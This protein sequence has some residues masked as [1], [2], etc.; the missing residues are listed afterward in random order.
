MYASLQDQS[1][2]RY[3]VV[4]KQKCTEWPQSDL[5]LVT[6]ESTCIHWMLTPEAQIS[7]RDAA[8]STLYILNTHTRGPNF[9]PFSSTRYR[10]VENR[11]CTEWP[12]SDFTHLTVTGYLYTLNTYLGGT[13]FTQLRSTVACFPDNW[14]FWFP[15]SAQWWISK[16]R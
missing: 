14:A 15:H 2:S 12:Q 6:V 13:N 3:K 16:I 1:F 4:E 8:Q 9:T 11:K 5:N 10:V 7:L